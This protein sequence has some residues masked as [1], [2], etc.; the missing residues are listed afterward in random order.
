M[1]FYKMLLLIAAAGIAAVSFA[2][3]SEIVIDQF[4]YRENA[5][6]IAV[7]RIFVP[8]GTGIPGVA[9]GPFKVIDEATGA[10]V[11]EG[12]PMPF[13]STGTG[14]VDAASGDMI[15][16]FDFSSVTSPGRYHILMDNPGVVR[17]YSFNIGSDVYKD[18][19]KAAVKYFYFQRAGIAKTA[20]YAGEWADGVQFDQDKRTRSWFAQNNAATERDLSGGW[21]DAGDYNKYTKWHADYIS[22]MIHIYEENPSAFTDDFGIPESGNGIPDII[23]EIKW[24]LEWLLKMQNED[25]SVLSIQGLGGGDYN[26]GG[27]TP[28]SSI[29]DPSYYGPANATAAFGAATAFAIASRFFSGRGEAVMGEELKIAALKAWEWG[30]ANP[31]SLF[32]NN[33]G[34]HGTEGLAAGQQEIT[35]DAHTEGRRENRATAAYYLYELTGEAPY[36]AEAEDGLKRLPLFKWGNFMDQYRHSSHMLYMRYLE[37]PSGR[38]SLKDSI[39][40]AMRTAFNNGNNF[41][42]NY[43]TGGYRSF[44]EN[45]QWGSNSVKANYGVTYYKWHIVDPSIDRNEFLNMA[46]GYL[47][48]IHGVNPLNMVYLT[49]M[50]HLGA[51]KS[52]ATIFHSWFSEASAKWSTTTASAPGPAPGFMPG[53]PNAGF[54]WDGCCNIPR[55]SDWQP[56]TDR[57]FLL[58]L[59]KGLPPA[60][61]YIETNMGWPVNSW[62]ITENSNGYQLAYIRLL[63]KFVGDGAHV[64]IRQRDMTPQSSK[65]NNI[66]YKRI[67]RGIELRVKDNAE[68]KIFAMNGAV[69]GRHKFTSGTHKVSL[70][71]LPK[72]MYIVRMSIDGQKKDLRIPLAH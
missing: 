49:N 68:V 55:C 7:G 67:P 19:L 38:E 16:H 50:N 5:R 13:N 63:S 10:S 53:G 11:F 28:P 14:N 34:T 25:G 60:K 36:L 23:D 64:S 30:I 31:D 41:Y 47:H 69:V 24:G 66:Q 71:K 45:Y 46:E 58:D 51:S 54:A 17:S 20:Q 12:S 39:R 2:V 35:D 8:P 61:M 6:K 3:P 4:G 48:Y 18:V 62:E 29:T 43:N 33:S 57:C 22:M 70:A 21:Y 56:N 72:G 65:V 42:R 40:T 1:Y 37:N 32:Y 27:S 15:W 9:P 26:N 59:P 52:A 44:I